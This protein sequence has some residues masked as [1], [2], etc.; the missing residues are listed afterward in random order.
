MDRA[1]AAIHKFVGKEHEHNTDVEEIQAKPVVQE[2]V[3]PQKK[4]VEQEVVKQVVHQDHYHTTIQPIKDRQVLPEEVIQ[5]MTPVQRKE[6]EHDNAAE[7]EARL[8]RESEKFKDTSVTETE[9]VTHVVAPEVTGE[10]V[11]HHGTLLG[12][13][14]SMCCADNLVQFMRSFNQ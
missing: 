7:V 6:Y 8:R 12:Y 10:H 4:V 1:K 11:H 2:V 5:E 9:K 3:Q 14:L 13:T